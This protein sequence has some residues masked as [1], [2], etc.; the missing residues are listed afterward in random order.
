MVAK[1]KKIPFGTITITE[2]TKKLIMEALESKRISSGRLVREFEEKFA[3]LYGVRDAVAVSTGT[4]ADALAMAVLYDYG[5]QRGDEIIIPSLSFVSTGNAVLH[6]GF[7]PVFVDIERETL[8]IN[9]GLVE[10]AVTE[11]TRAIMP[12]HLMGKPADMDRIN[13][14]ARRR[15][16]YV[17]EDA[18]E[19]HGALYRGRKIGTLGDISGI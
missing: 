7:T 15:S 8:N 10:Q 9:P 5:A 13:E 16:L 17:I 3:Q 18:A 11:R 1:K 12:V 14:I 2:K 6:A 4:D 19:A